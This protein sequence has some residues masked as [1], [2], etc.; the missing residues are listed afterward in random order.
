MAGYYAVKGAVDFKKEFLK[1]R[2][3]GEAKYAPS[4][5]YKIAHICAGPVKP[6]MVYAEDLTNQQ[7]VKMFYD[8][9]KFLY[10][11]YDLTGFYGPM[12]HSMPTYDDVLWTFQVAYQYYDWVV[13]PT[14]QLLSREE[15]QQIHQ[16]YGNKCVY[17]GA[18]SEEVDHVVPVSKGGTN[19][20]SNLVAS[21]RTCNRVK[22]DR[23]LAELGWEMMA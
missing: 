10:V 4:F 1:K 11:N 13:Q 23:T 3:T 9:A 14:R 15:R 22:S 18:P 20:F 8:T 2:R 21:C 16:H 12:L 5:L 19:E 7:S 17:C 6:A